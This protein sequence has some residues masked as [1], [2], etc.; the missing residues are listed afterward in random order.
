[1]DYDIV[2]NKTIGL[3][4]YEHRTERREMVSK[5]EIISSLSKFQYK[6]HIPKGVSTICKDTISF[7]D[8]LYPEQIEVIEEIFNRIND[9]YTYVLELPTG[10]GKSV[11]AMAVAILLYSMGKLDIK[12]NRSIV[13][14]NRLALQDQY[15]ASFPY[16]FNVKGRSQYS[17]VID[18]INNLKPIEQ[19]PC[20]TDPDFICNKEAVCAYKLSHDIVRSQYETYNKPIPIISTNYAW[21]LSHRFNYNYRT[22]DGIQIFDEVHVLPQLLMNT[23]NIDLNSLQSKYLMAFNLTKEYIIDLVDRKF[24]ENKIKSLSQITTV[25]ELLEVHKIIMTCGIYDAVKSIVEAN[26]FSHSDLRAY[27]MLVDTTTVIDTYKLLQSQAKNNVEITYCDGHFLINPLSSIINCMTEYSQYNLLMT[28]TTEEK[29][30][31]DNLLADH[32]RSKH[33]IAKGS[34]FDAD[35]RKILVLG[36]TRLG[37]SSFEDENTVSHLLNLVQIIMNHHSNERG[38][39]LTNSY[40]Q[41]ELIARLGSDRFIVQHKGDNLEG[42]LEQF[43]DDIT[44][45]KILISPAVSEGYDFKDDISRFQ[46]IIK[47]PFLPPGTPQ[48]KVYGDDWYYNETMN[49]LVQMCGRSIRNKND[50]AITYILDRNIDLLLKNARPPGWWLESYNATLP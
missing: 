10:Y 5:Q 39:I 41:T 45:N 16:L 7:K 27:N 9:T 22:I 35:N 34:L 11:I 33:Y 44:N 17:C 8:T 46:I 24:V 38:V 18:G 2:G 28:G 42:I 49:K 40:E 26:S 36:E 37:S 48:H 47:V 25:P 30:M 4:F 13:L 50:Y 6:Q 31:M 12:R 32:K 15:I 1:M 3:W 20:F 19:G 23:Y 14:T 29:Y 43:Y 21:Y